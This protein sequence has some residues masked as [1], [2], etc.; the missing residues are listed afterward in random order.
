MSLQEIEGDEISPV[1]R[2]GESAKI[3]PDCEARRD[4]GCPPVEVDGFLYHQIV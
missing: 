2:V 1:F 4:V 3:L